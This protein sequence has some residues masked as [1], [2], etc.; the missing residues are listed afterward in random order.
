MD[1]RNM[2]IGTGHVGIGSHGSQAE[3]G[4]LLKIQTIARIQGNHLRF[5]KKSLCK[6]SR[7]TRATPAI[8]EKVTLQT[9]ANHRGND[10]R[11]RKKSLCKQS[12]VTRATPAISEKVTLQIIAGLQGNPFHT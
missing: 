1:C 4:D 11:F 10:L 5:R 9:F 7:V 2:S 6:Q 8:S 12:Q 3:P